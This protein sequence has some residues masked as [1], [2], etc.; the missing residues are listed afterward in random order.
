MLNELIRQ[1][2]ADGSISS[3]LDSQA[4]ERLILCV[5]QGMRVIGKTGRSKQDMQAMANAALKL[6]GCVFCL[7]RTYS[8]P[9]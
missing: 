8:F 3:A 1:G 2:Q 7:F 9:Y 5:P 4:A 6:L